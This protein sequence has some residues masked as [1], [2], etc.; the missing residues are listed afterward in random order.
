M[1]AAQ[2]KKYMM[3]TS[4]IGF[5]AQIV[6]ASLAMI[7][8]PPDYS[9]EIP[10]YAPE[11]NMLIEFGLALLIAA[12]TGMGIK[13]AEEKKKLPATGF[14][15]LAISAGVMMAAL[16][17]TT[18]VST[19]EAYEKSYFIITSSYFLYLPAML[20]IACNDEFKTWLRWLGVISSVPLLISNILF[21]LHYRNFSVLDMVGLIG[22]VLLFLTQLF[23]AF[24]VYANYKT[25]LKSG[26][27]E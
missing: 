22:Y 13:L 12:A 26:A 3:L 5:G 6:C 8:Y 2:E 9:G 23:W 20:L 16:W 17:E 27:V 10:Y 11:S 4:V 1:K 24:N 18:T 19:E 15:M 21:L 25:E 7:I 14:T